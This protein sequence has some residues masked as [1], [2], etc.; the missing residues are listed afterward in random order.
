MALAPGAVGPS[1]R[2]PAAHYADLAQRL[3]AEG[4][5]VWV[6]GGPGEKEIAAQIVRTHQDGIRDLTGPD[7]RERY[8]A[9]PTWLEIGGLAHLESVGVVVVWALGRGTAE[10]Q[11]LGGGDPHWKIQ[12]T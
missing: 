1:K 3:A 12:V 6:I 7:L 8:G 5:W 9:K 2:W 11:S 4:T 10:V